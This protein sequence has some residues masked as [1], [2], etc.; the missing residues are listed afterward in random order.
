MSVPYLPHSR[1]GRKVT[2]MLRNKCFSRVA[3]Y[4]QPYD[5]Q[6]RRR[7]RQPSPLI[8]ERARVRAS[9]R[10]ATEGEA[11]PPEASARGH[12]GIVGGGSREGGEHQPHAPAAHRSRHRGPQGCKPP[13]GRNPIPTRGD[14]LPSPIAVSVGGRP[15][16][17]SEEWRT[18]SYVVGDLLADWLVK[19]CDRRPDPRLHIDALVTIAGLLDGGAVYGIRI[20]LTDYTVA[21]S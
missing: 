18:L 17:R 9:R 12:R 5:Q 4:G 16:Y 14:S 10:R 7:Q 19:W 6:P 3:C 8:P 20:K 13:P 1:T 15:G 11:A 21:H 2:K